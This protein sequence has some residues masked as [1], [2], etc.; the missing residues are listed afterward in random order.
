M[1]RSSPLRTHGDGRDTGELAGAARAI[2]NVQRIAET[3]TLLDPEGRVAR[4]AIAQAD[5][6]KS[7]G[8]QASEGRLAMG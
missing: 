5:R 4:V 8:R 1:F 7:L 2:A 3:D 6:C